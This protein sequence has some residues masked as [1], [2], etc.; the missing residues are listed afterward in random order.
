MTAQAA[1]KLT[2]AQRNRKRKATRALRKSSQ[3][4][5]AAFVDDARRVIPRRVLLDDTAV[6]HAEAGNEA[7]RG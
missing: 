7:N 3:E 5:C 2:S 1:P 6:F 4:I